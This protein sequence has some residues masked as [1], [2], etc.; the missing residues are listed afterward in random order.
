MCQV[1]FWKSPYTLERGAA[2]KVLASVLVLHAWTKILV[3]A[4][5]VAGIF[6]EHHE[7]SRALSRQRPD[8]FK[9]LC[10]QQRPV[11]PEAHDLRGCP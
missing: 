11:R 6:E 5:A 4:E 2:E 9:L 1:V 3:V 7:W 10:R 8:V